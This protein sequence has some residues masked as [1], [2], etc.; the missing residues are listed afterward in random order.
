MKF[1]V[2]VSCSKC[3][4][5]FKALGYAEL[6]FPPATC[7]NCGQ[8]IHIIEGLTFSIAAVR[9][10]YRSEAELASGDFTMPIICG[11][12]AIESALTSLFLKWKQLGHGFPGVPT[13][14]TDREAWEKEYRD[15]TRPGGFA[16]SA[17]F[18]SNCLT[19]KS[20]DDFVDDFIK[21]S[22]TV[23]LI[24][25]GLTVPE[26]QMKAA[27]IQSE[28]FNRR[29]RIMHWGEVKYEKADAEKALAAAGTA[30][31]LLTVMDKEKADEFN[32]ELRAKL[33][34]T[35]PTI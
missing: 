5:N 1:T 19:G 25:V 21:R 12:M 9:L 15:G 13:T 26:T 2:P 33:A 30:F 20:F 11:A 14:D 23:T 29:N 16:N 34:V 28:L 32:R 4:C 18:V 24:K 27:Y 10:L 35:P 8:T 3:G 6:T 31:A 17:N 7:P 22:K